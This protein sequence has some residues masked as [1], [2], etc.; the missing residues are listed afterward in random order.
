METS[1]NFDFDSGT[2]ADAFCMLQHNVRDDFFFY[3]CVCVC[4]CLLGL[5]I[6][7]EDLY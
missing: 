3:L 1:Q 2:A 6:S 4:V 5:V 7:G